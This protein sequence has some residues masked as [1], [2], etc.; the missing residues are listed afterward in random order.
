MKTST[1]SAQRQAVRRVA[2][3]MSSISIEKGSHTAWSAEGM[4]RQN[5]AGSMEME[6]AVRGFTNGGILRSSLKFAPVLILIMS[7]S[8]AR[9]AIFSL[10]L[11]SVEVCHQRK[12][13]GQSAVSRLVASVNVAVNKMRWQ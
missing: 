5:R 3:Q 6:T 1:L 11:D 8:I 9:L 12:S 10:L 7:L 2:A 13:L 4:K